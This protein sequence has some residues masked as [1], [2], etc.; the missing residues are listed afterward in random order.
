MSI[1]IVTIPFDKSKMDFNI[2][3]LENEMLNKKISEY[4][5]DI[6]NIIEKYRKVDENE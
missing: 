6:L 1:K 2:S 5:K 4:G 3:D